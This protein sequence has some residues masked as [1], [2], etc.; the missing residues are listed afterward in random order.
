MKNNISDRIKAHGTFLKKIDHAELSLL[1]R[2]IVRDAKSLDR[3]LLTFT[4]I[5]QII[6]LIHLYRQLDGYHH[7][8][9]DQK[10]DSIEDTL[11]RLMLDSKKTQY[12]KKL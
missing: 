5:N 1:G 2:K 4:Q 10:L 6:R 12:E 11:Q 9:S 3:T 7:E 8:M